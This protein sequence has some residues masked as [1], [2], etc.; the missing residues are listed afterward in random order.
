MELSSLS[1]KEIRKLAEQDSLPDGFLDACLAD[2]RTGVR[3]LAATLTRRLAA[4]AGEKARLEQMLAY[5]TQFA[6]KGCLPVGGVDEVGRGPLAGPVVAACV[7]LPLE[8]PIHGVNDSKQ[9]TPQKREALDVEIR[10]R[11]LGLG[12]GQVDAAGIDQLNIHR[13]TL[14]AMKEAVAACGPVRPAALLIDA[15]H[16]EDVEPPQVSLVRG[17]ERSYVVAAASIVAKVHR[18][19]LMIDLSQRYPRYHFEANKGYGTPDHMQALEKWGPCELHRRSFAPVAD[20]ALPS[21]R[22]FLESIG[23]ANTLTALRTAGV[24]IRD[25]GTHLTPSEL[26]TLRKAYRERL[27][28]LGVSIDTLPGAI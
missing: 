6:V 22:L 20:Y 17:D 2:G 18:D 7:V 3:K 26:S 25:T 1:E 10:R 16:L 23:R 13:A 27:R 11:A 21:C 4:A 14:R 19:H 8:D 28:L 15:M 12:L 24:R 9:L 5:E